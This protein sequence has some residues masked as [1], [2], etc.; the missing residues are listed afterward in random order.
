MIVRKGRGN[1]LALRRLELTMSCI[2]SGAVLAVEVDDAGADVDMLS[3]LTDDG[4][5]GR[6]RR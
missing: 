2:T 5:I 6:T 4:E 3:N 1:I